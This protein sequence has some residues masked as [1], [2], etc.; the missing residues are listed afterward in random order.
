MVSFFCVT[1]VVLCDGQTSHGIS[2]GC[3]PSA[4]AKA[5]DVGAPPEPSEVDREKL[6]GLWNRLGI[7]E[8][9]P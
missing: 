7:K 6:S 5:A 8:F 2:G 3:R 9:L 4:V 1:G